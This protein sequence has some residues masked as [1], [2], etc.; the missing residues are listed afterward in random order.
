LERRKKNA[1]ESDLSFGKTNKSLVI[2]RPTFL[3]SGRSRT[4]LHVASWRT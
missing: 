1:L 3:A 2:H 4:F